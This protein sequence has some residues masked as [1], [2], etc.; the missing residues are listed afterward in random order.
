[1][2]ISSKNIALKIITLI[3]LIILTI[4]LLVARD[5]IILISV[6]SILIIFCALSLFIALT[7][8]R[9]INIIYNLELTLFYLIMLFLALELSY[10]VVPGK[11]PPALRAYLAQD[12]IQQVRRNVVEYLQENPF[13]KF[14][15][16]CRVRSQGYRGAEDQFAYEWTTDRH[17]FKNPDNLRG[18]TEVDSIAVGDSFTEGMGVDTENIWP[19]LLTMAGSL[20]YN[21]GVQGY[22]PTQFAGVYHLYGD[23][24]HHKHVLLGYVSGT[25]VREHSFLDKNQAAEKRQY[26]GG[27]GSIAAADQGSEIRYTT[28]SVTVAIFM[29]LRNGFHNWYDQKKVDI[30]EQHKNNSHNYYLARYQAEINNVLN[31][32]DLILGINN[33]S[34][35]W[36]S[37]LQAFESI[38]Q[39]AKRN[40]ADVILIYFPSRGDMY[41]E[42]STGSKLP[43][44]CLNKTETRALARFCR[45][46]QVIFLDFSPIIAYYVNNLPDGSAPDQ[47][48]YLEIDGHLSKAGHRLVANTLLKLLQDT[49]SQTKGSFFNKSN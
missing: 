30:A 37:T 11:F 9:I 32:A 29:L 8:Y 2:N 49:T 7:H 4:F 34:P 45:E 41:F 3:N 5:F 38:I 48:P 24:Y 36:Q 10:M 18:K 47:Y 35:E 17:G 12:N 1:M 31:D 26:E 16:E 43:E 44:H 46:K 39:E 15:P 22:A 27:I 28:R 33:N 25:Y 14:K 42:K 19:A 20:T 21:L 6:T 23:K 13:V 40:G